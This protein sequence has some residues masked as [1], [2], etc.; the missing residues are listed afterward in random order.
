MTHGRIDDDLWFSDVLITIISSAINGGQCLAESRFV[1]GEFGQSESLSKIL[2]RYTDR[3]CLTVIV[4]SGLH[5][6]IYRYGNHG[7]HWEYVGDTIGYA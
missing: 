2:K 1:D 5:G 4:E 7:E 6:E 3:R